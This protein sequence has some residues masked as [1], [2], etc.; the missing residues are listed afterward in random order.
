MSDL[1]NN[2]W[3]SAGSRGRVPDSDTA[4]AAAEEQAPPRLVAELQRRVEELEVELRRHQEHEREVGAARLEAMRAA[5]T[6]RQEA[7]RE[8]QA[9][10]KKARAR[11]TELVEEATRDR[12]HVE[13]ELARRRAFAE[14]AEQGLVEVLQQGL[15]QLKALSSAGRP[16][17]RADG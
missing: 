12:R 6:I 11:A 7:R 14:Q 16:P 4:P 10:L 2:P 1:A 17:E 8:A 9:A 5:A 15:E 3:M 13:Q